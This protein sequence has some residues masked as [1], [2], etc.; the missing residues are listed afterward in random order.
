M[1]AM[2]CHVMMLI[3]SENFSHNSEYVDVNNIF[4]CDQRILQPLPPKQFN[5]LL[6][7]AKQIY[8][9]QKVSSLNILIHAM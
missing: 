6:L 8:F 4:F 7:W 3:H 9:S 5:G 2:R 1:Q